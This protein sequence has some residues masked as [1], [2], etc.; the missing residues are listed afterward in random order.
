MRSNPA[1][2]RV[3]KSLGGHPLPDR[4]TAIANQIG[5]SLLATQ[6]P[7]ILPKAKTDENPNST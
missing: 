4:N 6:K 5:R 1:K 7:V 2:L 3:I